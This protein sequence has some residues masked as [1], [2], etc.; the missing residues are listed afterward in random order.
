M[1]DGEEKLI[2]SAITGESSAFGRLY[3]EYQPKIYRFILI[4]VGHREEAEDLTH[5]VFLKAWQNI[6]TYEER[7][8]P[9]SGW[10][11]EIARNQVI[12]HYR[13][14]QV[15]TPLDFLEDHLVAEDNHEQSLDRQI[16]LKKIRTLMSKLTP[17]QE[18]V[19]LM[20]F[21][22]DLSVQEVS[23]IMKKSEGAVKLLQHRA[24]KRLRELLN[25]QNDERYG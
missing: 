22:D 12:D 24:I 4:K 1:L 23:K 16:S 3:D 21:V 14:K 9:F 18:D 20:R 15:H 5:Q 17:E 13:T 8:L 2:K 6:A 25:K 7:G 19:L 11:Y 10:L